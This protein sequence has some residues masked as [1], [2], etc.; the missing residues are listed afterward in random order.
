MRLGDPGKA[1]WAPAMIGEDPRKGPSEPGMSRAARSASWR[2]GAPGRSR[3]ARSPAQG[4]KEGHGMARMP[5]AAKISSKRLGVP[6]SA[7]C[8]AATAE[9]PGEGPGEARGR[10]ELVEEAHRAWK[11]AGLGLWL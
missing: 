5:V 10:Q 2:L 6:A 8:F 4:P 11:A 9:A 1:G 7:G 3:C